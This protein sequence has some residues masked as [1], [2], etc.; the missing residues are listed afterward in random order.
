MRPDTEAAI[1]AWVVYYLSLINK[2]AAETLRE[3]KK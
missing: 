1:H 3:G 2:R